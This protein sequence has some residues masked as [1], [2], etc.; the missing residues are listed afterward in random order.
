MSQLTHRRSFPAPP[1][2]A[3]A[4]VLR[5]HPQPD[6]FNHALAHAWQ[7]GTSGS[8]VETEVIDVSTL[9]FDPILHVGYRRDQPLEPDLVRVKEAIERAAH[10][11]VA[12]PMWWASTPAAL[13]GLFD[14]VLLPGWAFKYGPSGLPI[15]GLAGRSGRMLM[16]MDS[17]GWFAMFNHGRAA[18]RQVKDATLKFC[19][20]RPVKVSTFAGIGDTS[21]E[22]RRAMLERARRDGA[23]DARR[24]VRRFGEAPRAGQVIA[25]G[26]S[27]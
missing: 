5:A 23:R 8:G 27:A 2:E 4:L 13:K 18:R 1:T 10:L 14:R 25:E 20:I 24:L 11:V 12:F 7:E 3:R 19:G 17:P 21:A 6:S 16:T 15:G 22:Q 9:R 26:R